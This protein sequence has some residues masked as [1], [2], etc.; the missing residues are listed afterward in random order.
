MSGIHCHR[1][2]CSLREGSLKYRVAVHVRSM[3]D[4]VIP[5]DGVE[6]TGED[7]SRIMA[8]ISA[9]N[10][11]ELTRQVYENDEFIMCPACKEAFL[12][13]IYSHMRPKASPE[14]GRAHL[15]H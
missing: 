15:I 10:E 8:E 12:E 1:C 6:S 14:G 4:G 13:A 3:F 11:E 5:T 2:G 7:L 9:Y